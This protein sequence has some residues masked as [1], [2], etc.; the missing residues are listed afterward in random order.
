MHIGLK[1]FRP[2]IGLQGEI[3]LLAYTSAGLAILVALYAV[4]WL[5]R[6]AILNEQTVLNKGGH[7]LTANVGDELAIRQ[8]TLAAGLDAQ[9]ISA[10]ESV[11]GGNNVP[12]LT[13]ARE[14]LRDALRVPGVQKAIL[15]IPPNTSLSGDAQRLSAGEA[16]L[17]EAALSSGSVRYGHPF[18]I[19]QRAQVDL[20]IPLGAK[21]SPR[22]PA[23][24]ITLDLSHI[25]NSIESGLYQ[26]FGSTVPLAAFAPDGT[27]LFTN[28]NR[29][30]GHPIADPSL[31][32]LV[33]HHPQA[34][35]VTRSFYARYAEGKITAYIQ[36]IKFYGLDLYLLFGAYTPPLNM[37]F[38]LAL[39]I[40]LL[41]IGALLFQLGARR[42]VRPIKQFLAV[43]RATQNDDYSIR[44]PVQVDPEFQELAAALND[45][46]AVRG[47]MSRVREL[48]ANG[49]KEINT[50]GTESAVLRAVVS[51]A[52]TILGACMTAVFTPL[53]DEWLVPNYFAG[54]I[55][56]GL[57]QLRV[58][59][60][61]IQPEGG[62][63]IGAA[64]QK[65]LEVIAPLEPPFPPGLASAPWLVSS[66]RPLSG[67]IVAWPVTYQGKRLGVLAAFLRQTH[68]PSEV[69]VGTVRDLTFTL[70]SALHGLALREETMRSLISGLQVRDAETEEHALRT[71]AFTER[72]AVELGIN[73]PEELETIRWGALLHD[74]GKIGLPDA[75]LHK[76]GRL[77]E[78]EWA[79]VREH[80]V[81]G[82]RLVKD[83]DFLG[84]ACQIILY[85]HCRF[86]GTGYP[87]DLAG[88]AI[89]RYA[90]IF[91]VADAFDAMI[92][93]RPYRK[94]M[95]YQAA[96]AEIQRAAGSQLD[97]EMVATFTRIPREE[98]TILLQAVDRGAN[99]SLLIRHLT[100][101]GPEFKSEDPIS[102][103]ED[104]A[105][106]L[107]SLQTGYSV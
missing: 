88:T 56:D 74:V 92:S 5:P 86:D 23:E 99:I 76:A 43:A 87:A 36:P 106:A 82:Y 80:P 52:H 10:L 4:I 71:A 64:W 84:E 41:A 37:G 105:V 77:T 66:R 62:E 100:G 17:G 19:K 54:A 12:V 2:V 83:L 78:E 63:P 46:Q 21:S 81:L 18:L 39:S 73:N 104:T 97:P 40:I 89:P 3:A 26:Q 69:S 72:L 58:S 93:H 8:T 47:E 32:A 51:Y 35:V 59:T 34:P 38:F 20:A 33:R 50:A 7:L 28:T 70:A 75:I 101:N 29:G 57:S 79:I 1:R 65:G 9:E 96:L 44:V 102:C 49:Q 25:L 90:R 95:N 94:P 60:R 11:S 16:S 91:A 45:A 61:W 98:W 30:A 22:Q 15:F 48:L 107:P 85:H 24:L 103:L 53:D 68:P 6:Q 14:E 13:E 42:I 31:L 27:I 55:Y 67:W